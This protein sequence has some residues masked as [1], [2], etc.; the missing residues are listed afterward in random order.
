MSVVL[1]SGVIMV[2]PGTLLMDETMSLTPWIN[3]A[4]S[5][6][7]VN[8]GPWAMVAR[9]E[10]SMPILP[11]DLIPVDKYAVIVKT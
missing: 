5:A 3:T 1:L 10:E 2:R 4:L 6:A 11:R 9:R 7:L 8:H